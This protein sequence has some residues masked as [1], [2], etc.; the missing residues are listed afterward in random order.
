MP[1]GYP[2]FGGPIFYMIAFILFMLLFASFP[3]HFKAIGV[4]LIIFFVVRSLYK[5]YKENDKK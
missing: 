3:E 5:G 2:E 1:S 4:L